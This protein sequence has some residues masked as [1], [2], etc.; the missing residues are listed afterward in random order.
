MGKAATGE[1]FVAITPS[2]TTDIATKDG[3]FPRAVR[4]GTGG[5]AVLVAPDGSTATFTNIAD[6]ESIDCD[7]KRINSTGLTSCAN[8]VGIY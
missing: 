1:G 2:D 7:V 3:K 5:T 8:I 4:F 6:G